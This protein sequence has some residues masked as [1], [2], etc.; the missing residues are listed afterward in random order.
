[1]SLSHRRDQ[2]HRQIVDDLTPQAATRARISTERADRLRE[3]ILGHLPDD[4]TVDVVITAHVQTAAVLPADVDA[5]LSSNATD[6][7][8]A[9]A[10]QFL[11]GIDADY[12]VLVTGK[13]ADLTRIPLN[14]Q[15]TAD[16]AH[17][18]GLAFHELLHILKT[19]ITAIGELLDAEIDPQYHTQV[20]DL[21]NIIEDGAIESEAIH[22]ENFSDN[23]GIRLELTRRLHSETPDEIPEDGVVHYSFWDAVTSC[24]YNEAI[25]PTGISDVLLDEDD[26]RIQFRSESD[27]DAFQAI[28]T[29][30]CTLSREALA[31]R[32]ADRDDTTQTHDK[33]A[34]VRRARRVIQAWTDHIQSVLEADKQDQQRGQDHDQERGTG[35]EGTESQGQSRTQESDGGATDSSEPVS[36]GKNGGETSTRNEQPQNGTG[37]A[38]S[39]SGNAGTTLP[40]EFD[41]SEVTLSRE[42]TEDPHQ[43]IFEQPQITPDPNPNDIEDSPSDINSDDGESGSGGEGDT[44]I[45]DMGGSSPEKSSGNDSG[46]N[47]SDIENGESSS[48]NRA[49]HSDS[50]QTPPSRAEALAQAAEQA[51][52]RDTDETR[53]VNETE[54]GTE[55]IPTTGDESESKSSSATSQSTTDTA[56]S[57]QPRGKNSQI[58][59]GSFGNG[60]GNSDSV[61]TDEESASSSQNENEGGAHREPQGSQETGTAESDVDE[62]TRDSENTGSTGSTDSANSTSDGGEGVPDGPAHAQSSSRSEDE[63]QTAYEKA[64][65]GD[66]RA[67]HTEADREQIDQQALE[68]ELDELAGH[69]DRQRRQGTTDPGSDEDSEQA[70][71]S[72]YSPDSLT[73][74]DIL[75]VSDELVPPREWDEMEDGADRVAETLEMYLRLDRRKSTRRGLSAGAYDTRAGHRLAIGDSRVCKTRTMGNEKQYA[76]VLILDRSGSMRQGSPAKIDVATQ[77]LTRFALAAEDLGIRVAIIDFIHGDARLVKPFSIETRYVQATL[78][79]TACGGGTPLAD[80]IGLANDLVESQ[81]DDPLIIS[82]GDDQTSA[83]TVKD[84]IRRAYAPVCSLTIATDTE[85]GTLSGSASELSSYYERQET[86]YTPERLDDRLDQFASLLAGL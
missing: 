9:Q 21:I 65:T 39:T 47:R 17:Q 57:Q 26:D 30:L 78:L 28:H 82:V 71:G 3:F 72:G 86:V 31:I 80:A 54:T 11:D 37:G 67:A 60:E 70:G 76:L 84:V 13:G 7:E 8:R 69:L 73:D 29:E 6:I 45:D 33:T 35:Q 42:A 1:M 38:A 19:G 2:N 51:R 50:D 24:L 68:D 74:L 4:V 14:D 41:P 36:E 79:D 49:S 75:P 27:R 59:L 85:P 10:E 55:T 32:S 25:Y 64:L 66:E 15:L 63:D 43:S 62:N 56:E 20:H 44:G 81:G 40:E 46:R 16:H 53:P 34:S 58:T 18:F 12:L 5:I 48:D 77:A 23:A 61:G 22:G 52:E 83:A